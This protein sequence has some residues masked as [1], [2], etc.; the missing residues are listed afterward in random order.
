MPDKFSKE[1]R[2]FIMSRIGSKNTGIEKIVFAHLKE[3]SI[4]FKKHYKK[5]AGTPDVAIP[6]KKIAIFIDGDFW[7]GYRYFSWKNR[8]GSDFWKNKIEKN[9][10]RDQRNF[11][12]LRTQNWK[13]KRIWGH[14]LV[15]IRRD[16]TLNKIIELV[17]D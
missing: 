6:D 13:V 11:R 10:A 5:I 12:K 1:T 15:K 2:S 4:K 3:N 17:H 8:L 14:Q 9:I 7:H 16:E